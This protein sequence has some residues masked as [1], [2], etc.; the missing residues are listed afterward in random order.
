MIID[1]LKEHNQKEKV[2]FH[3]P[4]HN[5][6]RAFTGSIF[7]SAPFIYD[8]TELCGTDA[9]V[10][11]QGAI[12]EAEN[13][14]ASVYGA[15]HSFFLVNGSTGGILTMIYSAF[16]R[17]DRV[18]VDRF[19][20][21]SV[22]HA[23]QLTGITPIYLM[24]D[25]SDIP[26]IPGVLS[27]E[28]V[29]TA[30]AQYPDAKGLIITSPNYYGAAADLVSISKL[31]HDSGGLL[32]VDEAH[33]AHF[34]FSDRFPK[35]AMEQGADMSVVSLHKSMPSPN[36]TALLHI[37]DS[38]RVD[39]VR[40]TLRMFQTTSPSYVFLAAME[41]AVCFG[42]EQGREKTEE[43]LKL[44]APLRLQALDDPFKLLPDWKNKGLSGDDVDRIF[45]EQF[46][47]YAELSTESGLLLMCS[48]FHDADDFN[49]LSEALAYCDRLPDQEGL[50]VE[51]TMVSSMTVMATMSLDEVSAAEKTY[52]DVKNAAGKIC[53]KAVSAFPPCIPLLLPGEVIT[54]EQAEYLKELAESGKILT[55][56]ENGI[57]VIK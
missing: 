32:L 44:L 17:G 52:V 25:N 23:C 10:Q 37:A 55:G 31:V 28:T 54:K 33:G 53:A 26:G 8:T 41:Q 57:C 5:K 1:M 9:L 49:R 4:G 29:A 39:D 45:R 38:Q 14:I 35:T 12:L 40:A 19:C 56:M 43:I 16:H 34:P 15:A 42:T 13:R 18:L 30:L 51:K 50:S 36:Q 6:G 7:A 47:I 21:Q 2:S 22:L 11:P 46:G 20:H 27:S 48:W 24:P 3:M